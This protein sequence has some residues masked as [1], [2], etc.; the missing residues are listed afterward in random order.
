[1]LSGFGLGDEPIQIIESHVRIGAA[2]ERL[3]ELFA[4]H[5][6]QI[7]RHAG[8]GDAYQG[9]MGAAEIDHTQRLEELLRSVRVVQ[10]TANGGDVEACGRRQNGHLGLQPINNRQAGNV[11]KISPIVRYERQVM[12]DCRSADQ[13]V[14]P[15]RRQTAVK[16]MLIKFTKLPSDLAVDIQHFHVVQEV[17]KHRKM[18]ACLVRMPTTR[19][20]LVSLPKLKANQHIEGSDCCTAQYFRGAEQIFVSNEKTHHSG[21]GRL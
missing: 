5:G 1:M 21:S 16:K 13:K 20:R 14:H 2:G 4:D 17:V 18:L 10:P 15:R 8:R 9:T 6:Q 7:E 19:A 12:N 11:G 3:A